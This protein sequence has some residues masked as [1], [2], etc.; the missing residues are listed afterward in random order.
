MSVNGVENLVNGVGPLTFLLETFHKQYN[1]LVQLV[2]HASQAVNAAKC[3][4]S[5]IS[6]GGQEHSYH[7]GPDLD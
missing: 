4:I 1:P 7:K 2:E 5:K 3:N 6:R